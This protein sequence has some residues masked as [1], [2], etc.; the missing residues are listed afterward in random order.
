MRL[1]IIKYITMQYKILPKMLHTFNKT[2]C[3]YSMVFCQVLIL[4]L[5][6]LKCSDVYLC[7]LLLIIFW[8]I[9]IMYQKKKKTLEAGHFLKVS[10][11]DTTGIIESCSMSKYV[12][13]FGRILIPCSKCHQLSCLL[14]PLFAYETHELYLHMKRSI[15]FSIVFQKLIFCISSVLS[16]VIF[17]SNSWQ[18]PT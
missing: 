6:L 1:D 11:K 12:A 5:F 3:F 16:S 7:S 4:C 8:N 2:V 14:A 13:S 17:F 15:I 9:K 10:N 18:A